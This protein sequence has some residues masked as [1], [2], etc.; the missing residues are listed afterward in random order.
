MPEHGY[1]RGNIQ[2]A[3][4]PCQNRQ[5]AL[6]TFWKRHQWRYWL[7]VAEAEGIRLDDDGNPIGE[8]A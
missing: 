7:E 6:I 5:G 1:I 8:T 3:C 4:A 2:P